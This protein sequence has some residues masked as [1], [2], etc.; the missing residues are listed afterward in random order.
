MLTIFNGLNHTFVKRTK[1]M[2]TVLLTKVPYISKAL[3]WY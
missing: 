1:F 3:I 2:F